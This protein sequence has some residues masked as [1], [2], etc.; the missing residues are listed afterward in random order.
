M[1]EPENL[2]F[3]YNWNNKLNCTKS[4]STI[5]LANDS[6]YAEG[7]YFHIWLVEKHETT[8]KGIAMI[9]Y[10]KNFKLPELSEPMAQLDTGY[11]HTACLNLMHNMYKNIVKDWSTQQFCFIVFK[12][13]HD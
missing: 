10:C 7:K 2:K 8:D 11:D 4:F 9:T 6:R 3:S 1:Q 5:R 13:I 12:K